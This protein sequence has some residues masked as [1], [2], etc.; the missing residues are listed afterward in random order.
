MAVQRRVEQVYGKF[1]NCYHSF[2]FLL[3]SSIQTRYQLSGHHKSIVK[4]QQT[5][6]WKR[7]REEKSLKII[8]CISTQKQLERRIQANLN[9]ACTVGMICII[10]K[11][12]ILFLNCRIFGTSIYWLIYLH[13][14]VRKLLFDSLN[15]NKKSCL[16]LGLWYYQSLG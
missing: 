11:L 9:V 10:A 13:I 7:G 6:R 3:G 1:Q 12:A 5:H 2:V 15:K 14:F 8:L 16:L 4:K